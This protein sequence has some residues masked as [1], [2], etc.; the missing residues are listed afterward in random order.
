ME[1]QHQRADMMPHKANTPTELIKALYHV[2]LL[3]PFPISDGML[4]LWARSIQKLRPEIT[5]E[6]VTQIIDKMKLGEIKYDTK[7]GVQNIFIGYRELSVMKNRHL[8]IL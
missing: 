4:E 3:T 1:L 2:N 6:V 8:P 5:P 7:E